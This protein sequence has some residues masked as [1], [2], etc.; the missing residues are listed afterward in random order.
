MLFGMRRARA[1]PEPPSRLSNPLQ[2][3][4]AL[5]LAALFQLVLFAVFLM[6]RYYGDVG[7]VASGAVLG[8]TDAD[9]LTL[10]MARSVSQGVAPHVAA[11]GIA[12]GILSNSVVKAG[13]ALALGGPAFRKVAGAVLGATIAA[14]VAALLLLR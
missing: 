2:L 6:H 5:Q 12:A 1:A 13:I 3:W 10:S 14:L 9:A 4:P 8:L 11:R 7:M